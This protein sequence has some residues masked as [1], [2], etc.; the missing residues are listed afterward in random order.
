LV[1]VKEFKFI[2]YGYDD[3]LKL[4]DLAVSSNLGKW[5]GYNNICQETHQKL[6]CCNWFENSATDRVNL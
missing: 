5:S 3:Y 4:S 6:A 2:E 1:C